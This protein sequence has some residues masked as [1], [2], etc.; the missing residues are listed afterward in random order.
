MEE[1]EVLFGDE[2][3]EPEL[4]L[5]ELMAL[6]AIMPESSVPDTDAAG[7]DE[8]LMYQTMAPMTMIAT[9]AQMIVFDAVDI[10]IKD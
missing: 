9:M 4:A 1:S 10:D 6:A 5:L 3:D 8:L 2:T 7:V